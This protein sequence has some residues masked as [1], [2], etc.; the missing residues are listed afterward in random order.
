MGHTEA[1]GVL[2]VISDLCGRVDIACVLITSEYELD[3]RLHPEEETAISG[4]AVAKRRADFV[5]GRAAANRA[6]RQLGIEAP[7]PLRQG[8][9]REPLWPEGIVG[10]I[11]HS[12]PWTI[13]VAARRSAISAIGIDLESSARMK[14]E[15]ISRQIGSESELAWM[16]GFGDPVRA[17]T[18][19]FSSKEAVFKAFISPHCQRYF[20]FKDVQLVW[21]SERESFRGN[22]L[23]DLDEKYKRGYVFEVHCRSSDEW[24]FAHLIEDAA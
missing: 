10:S 17:L 6:M 22:L 13:A 16:R 2:D 8:K 11:T 9:L 14:E 18:M 12:R 3:Y 19:I 15:D 1:N 21:L 5:T 4:Q 20:D 7:P 24:V 23:V